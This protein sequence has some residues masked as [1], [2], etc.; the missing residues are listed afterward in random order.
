M[1]AHCLLQVIVYIA[2]PYAIWLAVVCVWLALRKL[3][4]WHRRRLFRRLRG[5]SPGAANTSAAAA[6]AAAATVAGATQNSAM[7][8]LGSAQQ[9]VGGSAGQGPQ[10]STS[11]NLFRQAG[12]GALLPL[13]LPTRLPPAM[14]IV[15]ISITILFLYY[16]VRVGGGSA[17]FWCS[18]EGWSLVGVGLHG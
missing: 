12:Q 1:I 7:D 3:R 18:L 8:P 11:F 4:T 17:L 13:K 2:V 15:I 10:K 16:E 5:N 9:S 14:G 6:A